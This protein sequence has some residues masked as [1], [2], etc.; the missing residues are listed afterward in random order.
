M[1]HDNARY[2]AVL[3]IILDIPTEQ[4]RLLYTLD[5]TTMLCTSYFT[6]QAR[7]GPPAQACKADPLDGGA[8]LAGAR[9]DDALA[10]GIKYKVKSMRGQS[11]LSPLV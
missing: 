6:L 1:L 5:S 3:C 11:K 7:R 8:A 2:H 4:A 9:P 10:L